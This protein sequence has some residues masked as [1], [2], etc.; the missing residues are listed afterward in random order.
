MNEQSDPSH[1]VYSVCVRSIMD[2]GW[3]RA[4][5]VKPVSTYRHYSEPPR[6]TLTLELADQAEL[7]GFLYRLH[8]LGLTLISVELSLPPVTQ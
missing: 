4:L 6:T 1:A 2:E 3:V 7:L 5:Q 8:N